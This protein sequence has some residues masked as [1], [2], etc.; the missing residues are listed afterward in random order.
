MR[1]ANAESPTRHICYVSES[2][3]LRSNTSVTAKFLSGIAGI[4][5]RI[6]LLDLVGAIRPNQEVADSRS[7]A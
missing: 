4:C 3:Q 7:E 5:Q 2:E 6:H 1:I